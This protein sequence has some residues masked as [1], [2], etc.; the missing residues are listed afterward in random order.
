MWKKKKGSKENN[1]FRG[2][3]RIENPLDTTD[4]QKVG[5]DHLDHTE[6]KEITHPLYYLPHKGE[7]LIYDRR[8][9]KVV[10]IYHHYNA[11]FAPYIEIVVKEKE[12]L[13]HYKKRGSRC[14]DEF[15]LSEDMRKW[16]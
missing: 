11:D 14:I 3:L 10:N 4:P 8:Y 9:Y 12:F 16:K 15:L 6:I 13:P 7:Y 2:F 5:K 1:N